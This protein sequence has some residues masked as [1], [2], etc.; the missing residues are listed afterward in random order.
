MGPE[1]PKS[2]VAQHS[3]SQNV[4]VCRIAVAEEPLWLSVASSIPYF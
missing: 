1:C 3:A 4:M 2:E